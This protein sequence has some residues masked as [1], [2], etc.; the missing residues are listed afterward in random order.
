[1][2]SAA[3][4]VIGALKVLPV[5][6]FPT[7]TFALLL[8]LRPFPPV[9]PLPIA[10]SKISA[11]GRVIGTT[12][13]FPVLPFPKFT[14]ALLL[15]LPPFP[16]VL[17]LPT[18]PLKRSAF[19]YPKGMILVAALVPSGSPILICVLSVG[20]SEMSGVEAMSSLPRLP[21]W[22]CKSYCEVSAV[23]H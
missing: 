20:F 10:P 5:S 3:G 12:P 4:R 18:A 11:A 14:F 21:V 17:P 13:V 8:P 9:L 7:F 22:A 15:P 2:I 23:S 1:M 16:P 6:P 19:G